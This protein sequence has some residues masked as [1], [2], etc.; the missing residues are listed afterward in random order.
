MKKVIIGFVVFILIV[1]LGA[2]VLLFTQIGNNILKPTIQEKI[3]GAL[4]KNI[5]VEVFSLRPSTLK[6][7][8]SFKGKRFLIVDGKLS[9][10]SKSMDLNYSLFIPKISDF[11]GNARIR[12]SL[13]TTGRVFGSFNSFKVVGKAEAFGGLVNY[14]V[15]IVNKKPLNL[16]VNGSGLKLEQALSMVNMPDYA[17]GI[18][19]VKAKFINLVGG[20]AKGRAVL[21]L[22]GGMTNPVVIEKQFNIKNARIPFTLLV[23][24]TAQGKLLHIKAELK[25]KIANVKLLNSDINLSSFSA[26]GLFKLTIP[27]LDNLYFLTERHMRGSLVADGNFR[28]DKSLVVNAVSKDLAGG[29]L[30]LN[31]VNGNVK[32][33]YR[34]GKLVKLLDM[35]EYP[36][37]FDSLVNVDLVYSLNTKKGESHVRLINGHF[38]PNRMSYLINTLAGFDITRELYKLSTIDSKIDNMVIISDLFMKSRLTEIM[39][40]NAYVNLKTNRID[41]TLNVMIAHKPLKIIVKGDINKPKVSI[42]I[43][44]YIKSRLKKKLKKGLKRELE[45]TIKV[46]K[47]LLHLF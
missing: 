34:N 38:L 30:K 16:V 27:N 19:S 23:Y 8:C 31:F 13:K 33:N 36:K 21:K 24:A 43:K 10:F 46:P 20:S 44:G 5:N 14:S 6:L 40:K 7:V 9:L 17:S 39:S 11:T 2:Y 22:S 3:S 35:L 25:S 47:G 18:V 15:K 26:K 45:K 42:N 28:K 32:V 37:V 4:K 41:A 12:G 29:I 1:V